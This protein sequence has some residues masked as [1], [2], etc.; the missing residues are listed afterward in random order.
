MDA[1][2]AAN[3]EGEYEMATKRIK[4]RAAAPAPADK[5]QAIWLAG[6]GAVSI[7]QKRG[8]DIFKT[9]VGEGKQF[10]V[11]SQKIAQE[12]GVDAKAQIDAA[13]KAGKVRA[14]QELA[15]AGAAV[16][17]GVATVLAKV[18]IPSKRDIEELTTRVTALS[19]Q[20]KTR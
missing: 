4:T 7:A 10:Q 5:T 17:H 1:A 16:Q 3:C 12:I 19:R 11:R 20:L 14:Q 13:L 9:L 18:G 8:G 15:K 2:L 6:L